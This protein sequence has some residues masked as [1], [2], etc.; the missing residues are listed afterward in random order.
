MSRRPLLDPP[1]D[2]SRAGKGEPTHARM[3]DQ[4]VARLVA[5]PRDDVDDAGREDLVDQL[6]EPECR[7]RG[8]LGRLEDDR[9]AGDER[10]N[11]LP[12]REHERVVERD[13][14]ADDAERLQQRVVDAVRLARDRLAARVQ[15][16]AGEVAEQ[17]DRLQGRVVAH[18]A[19]RTPVLAHVEQRELLGV[20]RDRVGEADHVAD[21]LERRSQTP[22]FERGLRRPHRVVDVLL[23][24]AREARDRLS[25]RRV[26]RVDRLA[27]PRLA[28]LAADE[29]REGLEC[30]L[31]RH[32]YLL[33]DSR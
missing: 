12:R 28:E 13:D 21:A 24:A 4:S 7:E 1:A 6:R 8:V 31:D 5:E 9:V 2:L 17:P 19:D 30:G 18:L 29:D 15:R 23:S 27:A 32:C 25:G 26:D 22:R 14:P 10:G 33:R 16:Q 20:R 11:H 3:H